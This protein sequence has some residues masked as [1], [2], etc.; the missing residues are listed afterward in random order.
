MGLISFREIHAAERAA[1]EAAAISEI[2]ETAN[3]PEP[4]EPA[5][6]AAAEPA[7]ATVKERTAQRGK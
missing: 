6:K 2:P 5:E 3:V 7:T 4:Q 1:R